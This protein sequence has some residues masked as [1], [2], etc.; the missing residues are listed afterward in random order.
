M[1]YESKVPASSVTNLEELFS[2]P[3]M[4]SYAQ[5]REDVMVYRELKA[6]GKGT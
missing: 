5:N 3:A 1:I 4:I 2:G 6:F